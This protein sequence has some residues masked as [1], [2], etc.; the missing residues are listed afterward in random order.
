MVKKGGIFFLLG[1]VGIF[2]INSSDIGKFKLY[3]RKI[4]KGSLLYWGKALNIINK[5][6]ILREKL[7]LTIWLNK[8]IKHPFFITMAKE[9]PAKIIDKHL[10]DQFYNF[11]K[12][13]AICW[14]K[15][16]SG[17]ITLSQ[18]FYDFKYDVLFLSFLN[19]PSAFIEC[20]ANIYIMDSLVNIYYN[21]DMN[22]G[23]L[24]YKY[25]GNIYLYHKGKVMKI[26]DI[27]ISD[28]RC[29]EDCSTY[30]F[31]FEDDKHKWVNINGKNIK[32]PKRCN[33]LYTDKNF[34]S[35]AVVCKSRRYKNKI[36]LIHEKDKKFLF[37]RI[38]HIRL[39]GKGIFYI[40]YNIK[41]N[42]TSDLYI[43]A[44]SKIHHRFNHTNSGI[45]WFYDAHPFDMIGSN[46]IYVLCNPN[47]QQANCKLY[48][49]SGQ[50]LASSLF[51]FNSFISIYGEPVVY[52]LSFLNNGKLALYRNKRV[53]TIFPSFYK[54]ATHYFSLYNNK[55][56]MLHFLFK[57]PPYEG[58]VIFL[59]H[60]TKIKKYK[61]N[62]AEAK[63]LTHFTTDGLLLHFYSIYDP[64][65]N[66]CFHV[67]E[68]TLK[69]VSLGKCRISSKSDTLKVVS[70]N[71]EP[72]TQS[73][74]IENKKHFTRKLNTSISISNYDIVFR[75]NILMWVGNEYQYSINGNYVYLQFLRVSLKDFHT[76]SL[77]R[78]PKISK[79]FY[80]PFYFDKIS[81]RIFF[82]V[83]NILFAVPL[84][85]F[86]DKYLYKIKIF[87][88][89]QKRLCK[90]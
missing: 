71:D 70:L 37:D 55:Y 28:F 62:I 26:P 42:Y 76:T 10:E 73:V 56:V 24:I 84:E 85:R 20:K 79:G 22:I 27:N 74:H 58:S 50:V 54:N 83:N 41:K 65:I 82:V 19:P 35:W 44:N 15:S 77:I 46:W 72:G 67:K 34:V 60:K 40:G 53:I 21:A 59:I 9:L 30:A 36:F 17:K 23:M 52:Y 78:A 69:K 87:C 29:N 14:V 61:V 5:Q 13:N 25:A 16:G 90:F 57:R 45:V 12:N 11:S 49:T 2:C 32:I 38:V 51:N 33:T 86:I 66:S 80:E 81:K 43:V 31:I 89:L 8:H 1:C 39:Y 7:K 75:K 64:N 3:I 47:F 68:L 18:F 48:S 6:R 63:V 88:T 4:N